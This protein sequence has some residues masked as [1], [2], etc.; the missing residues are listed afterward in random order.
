MEK[1][2]TYPLYSI[3]GL[4]CGPIIAA[5]I[6]LSPPPS[7]LTQQGWFTAAVGAWM[8]MWWM[9]EAVPLAVT[10]FLPLVLFPIL[11]IRGI[12]MTAESY[13]HP[14]I[15]LF[16]GGFLLAR[17]MNVWGLDRR[18]ALNVLLFSGDNPRVIIGAL[19]GVTAFLSMWISNTAT[20]MAMLPIAIS[21]AATLSKPENG[22]KQDPAPAMLLGIAYAAT[23]GGMGTIIGTPPNALFAAFMDDAYG[24]EI[25]FV[26]WMMIGVP[27]VLILLPITWL[28]L[29]RVTFRISNS[30]SLRTSEVVAQRLAELGTYSRAERYL[31]A[32]MLAVALG[33]IFQTPLTSVLPWLRLSDAGIA[34]TG[35]LLV[36]VIPLICRKVVFYWVGKKPSIFAGMCFYYSVVAWLWQRQ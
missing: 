29:T 26:R 15:F 21:I 36:F 24:I 2:S 27:L 7:G 12:N 18:L 25:G 4:F 33:W 20:A 22:S 13:A 1:Q 14:L 9:T 16:L 34:M 31:T 23:I 17:T 6:L 8:A 3:I 28:V 30:G 32:I 35:A 19:M 11:G 5:A 10:A